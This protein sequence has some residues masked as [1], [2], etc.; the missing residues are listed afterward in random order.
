MDLVTI[1]IVADIKTEQEEK[2]VTEYLL[3][4]YEGEEYR[5][6]VEKINSM[7]EMFFEHLFDEVPGYRE[8][9][10]DSKASFLKTITPFLQVQGKGRLVNS[11]FDHIED[12]NEPEGIRVYLLESGTMGFQYFNNGEWN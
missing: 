7:K 12:R 4:D 1:R 10:Q 8:L 6:I 5:Q 11:S 9:S 3:E 2:H